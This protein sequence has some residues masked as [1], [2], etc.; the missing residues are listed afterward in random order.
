MLGELGRAFQIHPTASPW[1]PYDARYPL[2][3]DPLVLVYSIILGGSTPPDRAEAVAVDTSG[4]AYV[5]GWTLSADFPTTAGAY[6]TSLRGYQDAFV[7]KVGPDGTILA[8]TF[9]GGGSYEYGYGITLDS[10]GNVYVTGSTESGNF[11]ATAGAYQTAL[12]GP[13]DAFVAK[14]NNNLSTLTYAT[15]LGGTG[16][17]R[18]TAIAL[19]QA[20]EAFVTGYTNSVNFPTT[21]GA[22]QTNP[23]GVPNAFVT[24]F[25]ADGSGL[26]FSTYLGGANFDEGYAIAVDG[27]GHVYVAGNTLSTNFPTLKP[28]Q[29][30]K[31]GG[32]DGGDVFVT[33]LLPD[34]SG[35]V[36]STYLGGSAGD[37]TYGIAA[38]GAGAAYVVGYTGSTDFPLANPIQPALAGETDLFVSKLA[39]TG[40]TLNLVYSTYLG[41][42]GE[43]E[44]SGIAVDVTGAAYVGGQTSSGDFPLKNPIPGISGYSFLTKINPGGTAWVYS[45]RLPEGARAIALDPLGRQICLAGGA[46][47]GR[48]SVMKVREEAAVNI[49]GAI[50]L[51]LEN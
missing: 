5:T 11:P 46:V 10:V 34:G 30:A 14:L 8:S 22:F 9:L 2:V 26:V 45:T 3:I 6:Q 27:S 20:G 35:L 29:A 42:S 48:A 23:P 44:N 38:D 7:T 33:K 32:A 4:N 39:L 21:A 37:A 17:D 18:G 13:A 15:Y 36:F 19:N 1:G 24:R 43:E 47:D 12:K 25:N 50:Y 40:D 49:V 41:G 28:W 16:G 31:A 51:L